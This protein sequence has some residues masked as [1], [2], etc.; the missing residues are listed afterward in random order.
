MAGK[1]ELAG[2]IAV[3]LLAVL[4]IAFF[5]G[6][7]SLII[8]YG[9][10]RSPDDVEATFFVGLMTSMV[11]FPFA[12]ISALTIGVPIFRFLHRRG[13]QSVVS[14]VAAGVLMSVVLGAAVASAHHFADFL[15]GGDYY[16]ALGIVAIGG[17][18]AALAVRFVSGAR[19]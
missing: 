15:I 9:I 3:G 7:S 8:P 18:V 17:P 2:G 16:V 1:S 5:V 6:I 11:T 14:Y 19:I 4:L 12:F 10:P 13:F